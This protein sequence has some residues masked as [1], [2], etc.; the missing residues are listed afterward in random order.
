MMKF[1]VPGDVLKQRITVPFRVAGSGERATVR[2]F[3][4]GADRVKGFAPVAPS[5]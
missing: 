4:F 5:G 2:A 1:A 3:R